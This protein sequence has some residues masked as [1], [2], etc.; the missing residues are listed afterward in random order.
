MKRSALIGLVSAFALAGCSAPAAAGQRY[1]VVPKV[2]VT[3]KP[4]K[5]KTAQVNYQAR[6]EESPL[7]GSG[8]SVR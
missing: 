3:V 1:S 6:P 7:T 5:K 2:Q 4:A 8:G